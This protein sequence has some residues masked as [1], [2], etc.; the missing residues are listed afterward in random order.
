MFNIPSKSF[1]YKAAAYYGTLSFGIIVAKKLEAPFLK[2]I[3]VE[4]AAQ[5]A[6]RARLQNRTDAQS[7]RQ[8][9]Y[10]WITE[11]L[12]SLPLVRVVTYITI[13]T[14]GFAETAEFP[15][16]LDKFW[17][18]GELGPL[19]QG[20]EKQMESPDGITWKPKTGL[21]KAPPLPRSV[22]QTPKF[23]LDLT[24]AAEDGILLPF[25]G[26]ETEFRKIAEI[27]GCQQKNGP[28]LL[29]P[30]GVGKTAI[31]KGL[32]Q[33]IVYRG[34]DLPSIFQ[35]K[36]IF[37]LKWE[38]ITVE[39]SPL[40]SVAGRLSSVLK[41]A[42]THKEKM[43]LFI[44]DIGGFFDFRPGQEEVSALL[45]SALADGSIYC[46]AAATA[47]EYEKLIVGSNILE[48][49][50]ALDRGPTIEIVEPNETEMLEIL[51][52]FIPTLEAHHGVQITSEAI[53]E[54][55][56]LCSRYLK[57][58]SFPAKAIDLLDQAASRL[59]AEKR[60]FEDQ[61]VKR[62]SIFIKFLI[63]LR[64]HAADPRLFNEKIQE[65]RR[66]FPNS[67]TGEL[68]RSVMAEK[69]ELPLEKMKGKEKDTLINLESL[70]SEKIIGQ[71]GPI[72]SLSGA[73]RRNSS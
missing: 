29:G 53:H 31:A 56:N 12:L 5:A 65:L 4:K 73:I 33:K 50:P 72:K 67:L 55:I 40:S 28:Y 13:S 43:I 10:H 22:T 41:E 38:L 32:A 44:D 27:L 37:L 70:L 61:K 59:S 66:G 16:D 49:S 45:K 3:E 47:S 39:A 57:T 35:G 19:I 58:E 51:Q 42:K 15:N 18:K 64:G 48:R 7:Y 69:V 2:A 26:R 17:E 60:P 6:A 21:K 52:A 20:L 25:V 63:D 24:K 54:C 30:Q 46:M 9:D 14:F 34:A 36:R 8:R 71:K 11:K 23:C 62:Y 68:I 1:F